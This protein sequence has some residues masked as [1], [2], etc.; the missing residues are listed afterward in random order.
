MSISNDECSTYGLLQKF[1]SALKNIEEFSISKDIFDNISLLDNFFSEFRNITF[2]A[3]KSFSDIGLRDEYEGIRNKYLISEDMRW[4][5]D[6]R[7][8]T[9]KQ[10]PFDLKKDIAFDFYLQSRKLTVIDDRLSLDYDEKFNTA[11]QFIE[12]ILI[13]KV[14][15]IEVFFSSRIIF[16]ENGTEID[17]YPLIVNGI[18]KMTM[19][20]NEI[21]FIAPCT[22]SKCSNLL[23]KIQEKKVLILAKEMSFSRDYS[24]EKGHIKPVDDDLD[25]L[26]VDEQGNV[27]KISE[28]RCSFSNDFWGED[29][30]LFSLFQKFIIMHVV[31]YQKSEHS[32][33]PVFMV[34]YNDNTYQL[35]PFYAPSKSAFY[36][37]VFHLID[38]LNFE[39]VF[40]I[41]YCGE[42]YIYNISKLEYLNQTPY[43]DRVK[44]SDK[45]L[46]AFVCITEDGKCFENHFDEDKIDDMEYIINEIENITC[47]EDNIQLNWLNPIIEKFKKNTHNIK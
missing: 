45:S 43:S 8:N 46:L 21:C 14:G 7:N 6:K 15:L 26:A 42:Y 4:F 44:N 16:K 37:N 31:M 19:F 47:M 10:K 11:R 24:F 3:Q 13:E 36:R 25:F 1:Y 33:M 5:V 18:E 17:I 30:C 28:I 39:E 9:T 32:I 20:I 2:V 12:K 34:I 29:T 23:L 40:T 35:K 27:T 38:S 22:C 41:F